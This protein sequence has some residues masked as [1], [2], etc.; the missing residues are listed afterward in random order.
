MTGADII[1]ALVLA[2]PA[3]INE[4]PA[5]R[6]K[7][8]KLPDNIELDALLIRT[9]SSVERRTLK[10]GATVRT[11]DRVSATVRAASYRNQAAM[12]LLLKNALAG[13]TGN[14]GGG[15]SV[16]VLHAGT[17]PDVNGPGNSFEQTID[18]K[19]SFQTAT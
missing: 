15:T 19:V 14:I 10:R 3:I 6:I 16:S 4:I 8:G 7:L 11:I 13:R 12:I 2:T 18:F 9:V 17:G 5:T 1:G